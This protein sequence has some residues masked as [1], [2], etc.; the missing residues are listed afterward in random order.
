MSEVILGFVTQFEQFSVDEYYG[1][2]YEELLKPTPV[3]I[4]NFAANLD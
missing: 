2:I 1:A 4:P 3:H